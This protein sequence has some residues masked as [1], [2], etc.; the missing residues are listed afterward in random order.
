[1]NCNKNLTATKQYAKVS[2]V[3][4]QGPGLTYDN[5]EKASYTKNLEARSE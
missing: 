1:M 4:L 5:R 3:F 2:L